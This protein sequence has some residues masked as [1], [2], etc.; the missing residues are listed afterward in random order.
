MSIQEFRY[1]ICPVGNASFLSA[2]REEFLQ[3]AFKKRGVK[4][5][6]LQSLPRD[7]WHVHFDYQD[8]ALF[9]EGGNIPPIW[10]KSND[11]DVVLIGLAFLPHREFILVRNDSGVDFVE[12]LRGLRLGVPVNADAIIDFYRETVEH[13]FETA[14]SARGV[15]AAEAEFVHL[16]AN[17]SFSSG[18][19]DHKNSLGQ[20]EAD[21]L[22][23][24]TVDAIYAGGVFAQRLLATGKFKPV[25]ELSADPALVLPINNSYPNALTVSRQ[26]A[27]EAPEIV[28]E[29]VKQALLAAKWAQSNYPAV[30]ELFT[31]QLHGTPGEVTTSLPLN[32]HKDLAPNLSEQALLALEG[33]K[34]FLYDHGYL[35][36]DFDLS[37]WADDRFLKAALAEI[38]Q[39]A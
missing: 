18:R 38:E 24:G 27:E 19:P 28:V 37:K 34:R 29:Y 14:L 6:L 1:T 12:Q 21:A 20:V 33:Q 15:A 23:A 16:S 39:D 8:P 11:A 31:R 22:E 36:K 5:T 9:R 4:S 2:N 17:V 25:Y 35:T 7:Q 32:F 13:G 3:T 26:L 30:L 10:A